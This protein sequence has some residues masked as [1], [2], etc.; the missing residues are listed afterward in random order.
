LTINQGC[1][2]VIFKRQYPAGTNIVYFFDNEKKRQD[3]AGLIEVYQPRSRTDTDA[4]VQT[5]E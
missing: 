1:F 5:N 3:K 4:Q 2:E